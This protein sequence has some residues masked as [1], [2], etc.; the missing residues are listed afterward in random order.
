M[1]EP[2]TSAHANATARRLGAIE[3]LAVPTGTAAATVIAGEP[4]TDPVCEARRFARIAA[5]PDTEFRAQFEELVVAGVYTV[6]HGRLLAMRIVGAGVRN[7]A[8]VVRTNGPEASPEL[9]DGLDTRPIMV[10]V[11]AERAQAEGLWELALSESRQRP[12][13][14]G[15]TGDGITY[16]GFGVLH[17]EAV[18]DALARVADLAPAQR[19]IAV[20]S[21][22]GPLELPAGLL[23]GVERATK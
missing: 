19:G 17:T 8:F 5:L 1:N 15:V 9:R 20:L 12:I 16:S 6:L 4:A 21:L 11:P 14:H 2:Q 3:R 10:E 7:L 22:G 23:V 13:F 18:L